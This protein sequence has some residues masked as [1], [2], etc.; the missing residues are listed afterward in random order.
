MCDKNTD[1]VKTTPSVEA[2][3]FPLNARAKNA[4][5]PFRTTLVAE[6]EV[7]GEL[8]PSSALRAGHVRQ[9]VRVVKEMDLNTA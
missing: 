9:R 1:S 4:H 5:K 8:L 2:D 7:M 3:S 6:A